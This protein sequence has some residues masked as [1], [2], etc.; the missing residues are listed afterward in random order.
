MNLNERIFN[1]LNNQ[2]RKQCQLAKYLNVQTNRISEW[3]N[4]NVKPSEKF[5]PKIAE[6]LHV[7]ENYLRTGEE[8][9]KKE[10]IQFQQPLFTQEDMEMLLKIKNLSSTERKEVEQFIDFKKSLEE[11]SATKKYNETVKKFTTSC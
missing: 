8:I 11:N 10:T 9:N 7:S 1:E 3:K 4:K 5:I 2:G 6:F